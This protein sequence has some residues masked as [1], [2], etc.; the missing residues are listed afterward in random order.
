[1]MKDDFRARISNDYEQD[2][3]LYMF[4]IEV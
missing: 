2:A 4:K 3:P 1:M